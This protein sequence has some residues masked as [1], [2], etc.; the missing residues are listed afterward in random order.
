MAGGASLAGLSNVVGVAGS[1][2]T[3]TAGEICQVCGVLATAEYCLETVLQLETK[4]KE[5]VS[6]P[7]LQDQITFSA[8]LDVFHLVV[9][10]C[11]QLLVADLESACDPAFTA[12]LK[13]RC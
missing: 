1:G 8:E 11:I 2:S 5:K 4:L 6:S 9:N 13:V 7:A 10:Q 3:Y 12:M